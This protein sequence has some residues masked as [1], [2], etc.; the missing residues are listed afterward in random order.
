MRVQII[1]KNSQR[2][3]IY[4]KNS[5][6]S[7]HV[8]F[9]GLVS[10]NYS[11]LG[12]GGFGRHTWARSSVKDHDTKA[13]QRTVEVSIAAAP[14]ANPILYSVKCSHTFYD[15]PPVILTNTRGYNPDS[16]ERYT[17]SERYAALPGGPYFVL[18][19]PII[20]TLLFQTG[21][22]VR[23]YI[24]HSVSQIYHAAKRTE[25][26]PMRMPKQDQGRMS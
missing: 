5:G 17:F 14:R 10:L 12:L 1:K 21:S 25:S 23:L 7:T 2:D 18:V 16:T 20:L 3:Y 9:D 13:F 6:I 11:R 19:H 15:F 22:R 8:C 24:F 4:R 26:S